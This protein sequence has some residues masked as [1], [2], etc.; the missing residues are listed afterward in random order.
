MV[1]GAA[2]T[3]VTVVN[4]NTVTFVTAAHPDSSTLSSR[5]VLTTPCGSAVGEGFSY[6]T[7]A[8]S[9]GAITPATGCKTPAHAAGV[10]DVVVTTTGAVDVGVTATGTVTKT[11]A[12]T[13]QAAS[14]NTAPTVNAGI[15]QTI[16]LP[17]TA[18]LIGTAA[19]DG[20][21]IP[22]AL[23]TLWTKQSGPGTVSFSDEESLVTTAT[24]SKA[25]TYLLLLTANDGTLAS[26]GSVQVVVTPVPTPYD[27]WAI[28]SGLD[29]TFGNE[30]GTVDDPD[31]D[32]VVNLL[33]YASGMNPR[34]SDPVP[35]C[36]TVNGANLEFVYR[37]NKSA[38]DVSVTVEW[39]DTLGNDWSTIGVSAPS[40]LSDNG[41]SQ[42][43][44]VTL[45]VGSG[46]KRRFVHLKVTKP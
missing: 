29:G 26:T 13:Y 34:A 45:P 46:V 33:E 24:F 35:C 15:N 23:P 40:I 32:G 39:S 8:A 14:F 31:G 28:S 18:T 1:G 19:D 42:Q 5:I 16:A 41:E 22:A 20:L 30:A 11:G 7:P 9:I 4:N 38:T 17:N 44:K 37:K 10:V 2:A 3:G 12:F 21:P 27:L 43:L 6:K 25:G 36:C